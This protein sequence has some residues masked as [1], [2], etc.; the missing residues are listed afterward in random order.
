MK[1]IRERNLLWNTVKLI[2]GN[3]EITCLDLAKE[4]NYSVV[5]AKNIIDKYTEMKLS[6]P[7]LEIPY[8]QAVGAAIVAAKHWIKSN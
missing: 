4:L 7:K 6:R 3:G 2:W 8:A 5:T 1:D